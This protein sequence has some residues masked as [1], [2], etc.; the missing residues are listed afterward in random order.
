MSNIVYDAPKEL[1]HLWDALMW[2]LHN[3][4]TVRNT[5]APAPSKDNYEAPVFATLAIQRTQHHGLASPGQ[6]RSFECV[7]DMSDEE[8]EEWSGR[9][10]SMVMGINL[11][12]LEP[13]PMYA[14]H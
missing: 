1:S 12:G 9:I 2:V 4:V 7:K 8:W 13:G 6:V 11:G 3:A 10:K 14:R 5:D